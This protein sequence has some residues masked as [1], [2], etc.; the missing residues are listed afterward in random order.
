[1]AI[2]KWEFR[3]LR[4]EFYHAAAVH[5]PRPAM[6]ITSQTHQL[7][8]ICHVRGI[9]MEVGTMMLASHEETRALEEER[10]SSS[11]ILARSGRDLRKAILPGTACPP[12]VN[13]SCQHLLHLPERLYTRRGKRLEAY[14]VSLMRISHAMAMLKGDICSSCLDPKLM[15]TEQS[16]I[17]IARA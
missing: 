16:M 12:P 14:V 9:S 11:D 17:R 4:W 13:S 5:S 7:L 8:D 15:G 3:S 1:M 2:L 10:W 6:C